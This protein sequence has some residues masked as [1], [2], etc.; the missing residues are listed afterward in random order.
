MKQIAFIFFLFL[1]QITLAARAVV[2]VLEA[3]LMNKPSLDAQ[4][5]QVVRRGDIV[6]LHNQH[7]TA[8]EWDPSSHLSEEIRMVD[9]ANKEEFFQTISKDGQ[10]AYVQAKF[11]KVIFQDTR[12]MGDPVARFDIDPTDYRLSEPLPK[13][14]P[15]MANEKQ[16]GS[17]L[18]TF[19]TNAKASY[20]FTTANVN[21]ENFDQSIGFQFIYARKV[22]FDLYDR[23]YFGAKFGFDNHDV[24]LG[25]NNGDSAKQSIGHFHAGPYI[26]YD[27]YKTANTRLTA[28]ASL[29]VSFHRA[30]IT[31]TRNDGQQE[32][33]A[34]SAWGVTPEI[35]GQWQWL[36][37]IVPDFDIVAGAH[38]IVQP[39]TALTPAG[40]SSSSYWNQESDALNLKSGMRAMFVLGVQSRY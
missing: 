28:F 36:D 15:L 12:E 11:V 9:E 39:G 14:Y 7:F 3:P 6:Y 16:R 24:S 10:P 30:Y 22:S 38:L 17:A 32:E 35:G 25:F 1:P 19:G 18:F 13:D 26:S 33:R 34:F 31:Y 40:E 23:F 21:N 20:D 4:V 37:F 27:V 8:T 2:I 29:A 5:K